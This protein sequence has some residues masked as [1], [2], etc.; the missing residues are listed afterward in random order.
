MSEL[1]AK[2]FVEL[3]R[4]IYDVLP[5]PQRTPFPEKSSLINLYNGLGS[6]VGF[7]RFSKETF[8]ELCGCALQECKYMPAP[9]WFNEKASELSAPGRQVMTAESLLAIAPAAEPD[10]PEAQARIKLL[11]AEAEASAIKARKE[12]E[13]RAKA[14]IDTAFPGGCDPKFTAWIEAN[15]RQLCDRLPRTVRRSG[16]NRQLLIFL[17]QRESHSQ[18]SYIEHLDGG[19]TDMKSYWESLARTGQ[20]Q[21]AAH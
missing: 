14:L 21:L 8:E 11:I 15:L 6:V 12:K 10:D 13:D 5:N 9:A 17:L 7:R 16:S 4:S 2:D 1:T 19:S 3:Y 20:R 18:V